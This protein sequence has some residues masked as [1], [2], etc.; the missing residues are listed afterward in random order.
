MA[1]PKAQTIQQRFG[2][3]DEDLK[4]PKH[5]ELMTWLNDNV[6]E[7]I[8]EWLNIPSEW[9][10]EEIEQAKRYGTSNRAGKIQSLQK[11]LERE[12]SYLGFDNNE[13]R[14]RERDERISILEK[15]IEQASGSIRIS[16]TPNKPP[17]RIT[18]KEWEKPIKSNDYIIGFIDMVVHFQV[19]Q[20]SI[21]LELTE[22]GW[23]AK[24]ISSYTGE[25][26][27]NFEV[28]T[29]IP[30]LGE[31]IR[32]IN[33]YKSY[34]AKNIFVVAPDDTHKKTLQEQDIGFIKCM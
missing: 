13:E 14:K 34:G 9:T 7:K 22:N 2:F 25:N 23:S 19:P 4:K 11:E 24:W 8:F 16:N 18:K 31:L 33:M 29:E 21:S 10:K 32:Q 12:K 20:I 3:M 30:S 1:K 27:I 5:D 6:E 28:K 15:Q 26:R 17:V